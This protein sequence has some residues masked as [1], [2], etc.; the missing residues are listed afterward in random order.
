[1]TREEFDATVEALKDLLRE[2]RSQVDWEENGNFEN[3]VDWMLEQ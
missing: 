3:F 1:M 2:W